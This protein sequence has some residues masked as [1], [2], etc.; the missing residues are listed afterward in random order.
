LRERT[1]LTEENS[2]DRCFE[3]R[4]EGGNSSDKDVL[5]RADWRERTH[6]AD[7]SRTEWREGTN[8]TEMF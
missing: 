1:H 2:P 6:L 4:L 8:L 3:D 5:R 7:V